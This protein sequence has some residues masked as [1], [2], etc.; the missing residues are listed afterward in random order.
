[1][2]VNTPSLF[3]PSKTWDGHTATLYEK[4]LDLRQ[5]SDL[6]AGTPG[7]NVSLHGCAHNAQAGDV[8]ARLPDAGVS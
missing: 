8:A 1:M 2:V 7:E 3:S 6:L 5:Q 4:Q